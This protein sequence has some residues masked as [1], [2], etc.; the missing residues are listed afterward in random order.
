MVL[1]WYTQTDGSFILL[2]SHG[3]S[4]LLHI[5]APLSID[6]H[7]TSDLDH[8]RTLQ[9]GFFTP[10][11]SSYGRIV[12]RTNFHFIAAKTDVPKSPEPSLESGFRLWGLE[13]ESR[14]IR[15][16]SRLKWLH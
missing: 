7:L 6:Y 15:R 1:L 16:S 10:T 8:L 12:L 11:S 9:L 14:E 13:Q 4:I 2:S 3:T 5:S